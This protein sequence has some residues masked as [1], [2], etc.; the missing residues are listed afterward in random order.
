MPH[1]VQVQNEYAKHSFSIVAST[2][3]SVELTQAFADEHAINFPILA[4]APAVREA[5]GVGLIWGSSFFLV[6]P[7]GQIVAQDLD[8]CEA[9]LAEELGEATAE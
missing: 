3:D 1:L 8:A 5:Y 7:E 9:R 2:D 6:D 4:D